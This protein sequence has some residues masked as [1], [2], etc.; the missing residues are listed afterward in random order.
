MS[1]TGNGS[2]TLA[3]L[4]RGEQPRA[5]Q[6]T[7]GLWDPLTTTCEPFSDFASF[8]SPCSRFPSFFPDRR[9]ESRIHR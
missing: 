3:S 4:S 1:E 2:D 8:F 9:L 6:D 5:Q 7:E